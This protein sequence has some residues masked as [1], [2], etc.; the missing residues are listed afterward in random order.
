MKNFFDEYLAIPTALLF[1]LFLMPTVFIGGLTFA[2]HLFGFLPDS[3]L[4]E[5]PSEVKK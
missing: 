1:L 4:C 5:K 2:I 3:G